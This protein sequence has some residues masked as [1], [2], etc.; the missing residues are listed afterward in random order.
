MKDHLPISY[1]MPKLIGVLLP[2]FG[3]MLTGCPAHTKQRPNVIVIITD[4][5]G[6]GDLSCHGNPHIRTPNLDALHG[7]SVRLTNFHVDPTCSPTRAALMTGRYSTRVGVWLT[8]GGRNHLR[9]DEVTLADAFK[10]NGYDTGIFREMAPGGQL[11]LSS[12]GP[13]L[14]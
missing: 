13:R 11:S 12:A 14:R 3:I 5:Q 10:H 8:Y 7:E 2:L 1:F 9:K 6:Y 4:D